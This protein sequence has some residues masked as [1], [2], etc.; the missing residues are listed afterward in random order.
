MP[1]LT[2]ARQDHEE[3]DY[4][5]FLTVNRYLFR[6]ERPRRA[7]ALAIHLNRVAREHPAQ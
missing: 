3:P 6:A 1:M 2:S 4:V 7:C 5:A